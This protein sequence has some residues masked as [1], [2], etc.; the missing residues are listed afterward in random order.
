[1]EKE[2]SINGRKITYFEEGEGPPFLIIHGWAPR[3][4]SL[5]FEFQ[6]LL[7]N[8][9][10]RVILLN[11]PGFGRNGFFPF[12]WGM[13][14]YIKCILDFADKLNLD[15]FSLIGHSLGGTMSIRLAITYPERVKHLILLSPGIIPGTNLIIFVLGWRLF[16]IFLHGWLATIKIGEFFLSLFTVIFKN[17]SL[18]IIKLVRIGKVVYWLEN[19]SKRTSRKIMGWLNSLRFRYRLVK[20]LKFVTGSENTFSSLPELKHHV[21]TIW[22]ERDYNFD[23]S[24]RFMGRIPNYD[25]KIIPRVGHEFH[26]DVPEKTVEL[27]MDFIKK[28][29]ET[30]EKS[31]PGQEKAEVL[32]ATF[33]KGKPEGENEGK[34]RHK[35]QTRAEKLKYLEAAEQERIEAQRTN[36]KKKPA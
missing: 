15:K 13:N 5:F 3:A 20:I 31:M 6:K 14:E 7:A 33:E 19:Y 4:A 22:G 9:G 23:W 11:L 24:A 29:D 32:G 21:L 17:S 25:F 36:P 10:Y 26:K 1:M 35:L 18:F 34:W 28:L 30:E 2:V 8:Y 12:K 16:T 27:I